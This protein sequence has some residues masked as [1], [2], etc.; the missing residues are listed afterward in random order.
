MSLFSVIIIL[1][2]AGPQSQV[3]S[4]QLH[5]G[6]SIFILIFID[7]FDVGNGV[8]EGSLGDAASLFG[9]AQGL[10]KEKTS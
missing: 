8:I 5:N 9:T 10:H 2:F 6:R 1:Q 4:D 7:M 3:V